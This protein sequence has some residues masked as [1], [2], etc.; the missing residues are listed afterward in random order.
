MFCLWTGAYFEL[1]ERQNFCFSSS[2]FYW[3]SDSDDGVKTGGTSMASP[4]DAVSDNGF[5]AS[6]SQGRLCEAFSECMALHR[7]V[8]ETCIYIQRSYCGRKNRNS[9]NHCW[10]LIIY[11]PNLRWNPMKPTWNHPKLWF[12]MFKTLCSPVRYAKQCCSILG[13]TQQEKETGK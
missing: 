12:N 11:I 13:E 10:I 7:C 8:R 5:W 2:S 1:L 9:L 6:C 4:P 3:P